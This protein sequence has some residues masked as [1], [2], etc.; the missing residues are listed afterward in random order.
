MV[1]RVVGLHSA[2]LARE[3]DRGCQIRSLRADHQKGMDGSGGIGGALDEFEEPVFRV[4]LIG[5]GGAEL[6]VAGSGEDCGED[7]SLQ[8][9]GKLSGDLSESR[10]STL[11][12]LVDIIY[13]AVGVS[14]LHLGALPV[15]DQFDHAACYRQALCVRFG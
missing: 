10:R 1:R 7:F 9:A 15:L 13:E 14:P 3:S 5:G 11:W 8:F 2:K 12:S 4:G 6:I